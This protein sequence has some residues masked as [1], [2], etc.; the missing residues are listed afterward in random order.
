MSISF[1]GVF[2]RNMKFKRQGLLLAVFIVINISLVNFPNLSGNLD[3]L[4]L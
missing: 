1:K 3:V 4:Y 2:V